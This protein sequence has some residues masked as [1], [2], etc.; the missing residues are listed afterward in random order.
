MQLLNGSRVNL[1]SFKFHPA[2]ALCR[3]SLKSLSITRLE[4]ARSFDSRCIFRRNRETVLRDNFRS[5]QRRLVIFL[6]TTRYK[7][8]DGEFV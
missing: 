6:R 7:M 2:A 8:K 3:K 4:E 5:E 1:G